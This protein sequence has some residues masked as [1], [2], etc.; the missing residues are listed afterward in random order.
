MA[1][2]ARV[3]TDRRIIRAARAR[4][5]HLRMELRRNALHAKRQGIDRPREKG[6]GEGKWSTTPSQEADE[7]LPPP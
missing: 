6:Q 4:P 5:L 2:R 1:P 3:G 7:S